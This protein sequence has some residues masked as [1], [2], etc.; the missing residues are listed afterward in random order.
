MPAQ[1]GF[2]SFGMGEH[3][4]S[5][6]RRVVDVVLRPTVASDVAILFE[7]QCDPLSNQMAG[8]RPRDWATFESLWE[9]ILR[10]S[11]GVGVVPR[12]IVVDGEVVGAINVFPQEGM[13]AIGYWIARSHWGRGIAKRSVAI[14]IAEVSRRPLYARVVVENV[15]SIRA[16]EGNGFV[17]ISR[18]RSEGTDRYV[19]SDTVLF[20]LGGEMV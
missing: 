16:L 15:A 2:I 6:R 4:P 17:E 1:R 3:T 18:E 20:R 9:K 14:L 8:T 19:A 5:D 12:A 10:Q 13:E 11:E 7:Q